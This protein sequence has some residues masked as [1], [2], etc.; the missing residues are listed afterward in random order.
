M[1]PS[2]TADQSANT[3]KNF[4][5]KHMNADH[6]KSLAMYLRVYCHVS[7]SEAKSA[8]LED[9]SLSDLLLSARGTRYTVPLDPPM[10][11][12]SE[13]RG[14]VVAMHKECLQKLGLSDITINEYRVP[15]GVGAVG[16]AVCL[17]AIVGFCQRDNFLPGSLVYETIGLDN[18]PAMARL[19][20]KVQPAV[21]IFLLGAH[22]IEAALLT[23]KR[24]KPHGVPFLSATWF[25][26]VLSTVVE[27]FGAWIRFD[28]M[29]QEKRGG[30]EHNDPVTFDQKGNR[31]A[32]IIYAKPR[33]AKSRDARLD[34]SGPSAV[35]NRATFDTSE[36]QCEIH[37]SPTTSSSTPRRQP[38]RPLPAAFL[39]K[40]CRI[41][42]EFLVI[43]SA[44]DI[45]LLFLLSLVLAPCVV[46]RGQSRLA[47]IR[48]GIGI[49]TSK[50]TRRFTTDKKKK[51]FQT[52]KL[53]SASLWFFHLRHN[54]LE[55]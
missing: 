30:K 9:I 17:A 54:G 33:D 13:T 14:R 36:P 27:G 7:T 31:S 48:V 21:F 26:W 22:A 4:I 19:C 35:W 43:S 40:G 1:A 18:F 11:S 39:V 49:E 15:R 6:Q 47:S 12:F 25:A 5:I 2:N 50:R 55:R 23:V 32:D 29:V 41:R 46:R 34:L 3:T 20:Y 37:E 51:K 52:S 38:H 53:T 24:L 42:G 44:L 8:R 10:A 45:S 16:F 28:A